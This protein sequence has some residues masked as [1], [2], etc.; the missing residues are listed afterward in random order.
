MSTTKQTLLINFDI[1]SN[2]KSAT[3]TTTVHAY[4]ETITTV[5]TSGTFSP[6]HSYYG[7][8]HLGYSPV[9]DPHYRSQH[10][11]KQVKNPYFRVGWN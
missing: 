11:P 4:S 7:K 1:S 6:I 9:P 2:F 3:E 5:T 10:I 8:P